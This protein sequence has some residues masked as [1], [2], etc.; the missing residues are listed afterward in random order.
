M[1][2]LNRE[3]LLELSPPEYHNRIKLFL[4]YAPHLDLREVA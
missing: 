2:D 1:D 4:D 3:L